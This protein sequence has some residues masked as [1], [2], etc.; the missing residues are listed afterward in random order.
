MRFG[1]NVEG[2]LKAIDL[3]FERA[4][5]PDADVYKAALRTL[6]LARH[7]LC[8]DRLSRLGVLFTKQPCM[9]D[10][11]RRASY[12]LPGTCFYSQGLVHGSC[13]HQPDLLLRAQ[14]YR[15]HKKEYP[16]PDRLLPE[17][18]VTCPDPA[19]VW[20]SPCSHAHARVCHGCKQA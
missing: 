5:A 7:H 8:R 10:V 9:T 19:D 18:C 15:K 2:C 11:R 3:G 12:L 4:P 13:Q 6:E 14:A 16:T 20:C 17:P 1:V